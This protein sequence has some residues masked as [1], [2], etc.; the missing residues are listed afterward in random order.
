MLQEQ[1]VS[2]AP[3]VPRRYATNASTARWWDACDSAAS[4]LLL[5]SRDGAKPCASQRPHTSATAASRHSGGE[6]AR[7]WRRAVKPTLI[8]RTL[9]LAL[10]APRNCSSTPAKSP[11]CSS[12]TIA[13]SVMPAATDVEWFETVLSVEPDEGVRDAMR[14]PPVSPRPGGMV[15]GGVVIKPVPPQSR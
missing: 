11:A 7:V 12:A 4:T 13:D 2:A 6:L 14:E 1:V 15:G 8:M 5:S 10:S 9:M 3:G